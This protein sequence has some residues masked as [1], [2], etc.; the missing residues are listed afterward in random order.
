MRYLINDRENE[1]I[2]RFNAL[3][4]AI[5][6][7]AEAF[8]SPAQTAALRSYDFPGNARQR[9]PAE[10]WQRRLRGMARGE[11]FLI[12]YLI[13]HP[14]AHFAE[15]GCGLGTWCFLA[16]LAGAQDVTG[17]DLNRERL[18]TADQIARNILP[19][20]SSA[21][22]Q[23]LYQSLF[24]AQ[25]QRPVDVFYLK[26]AIHHI[27]PLDQLFE[28]LRKNLS[29]GG[30]V[31]VHDSNAWHPL[32]QWQAWRDR[33]LRK[34]ASMPDPETGERIQYAV[35]DFLSVP[36]LIRQ[37]RRHGFE[38]AHAEAYVG[39]RAR[40]DDRL[41]E[42]ILKPLNQTLPISSLFAMT[43]QIVARAK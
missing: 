26:A 9:L 23:F 20:F 5:T 38:I 29:P 11:Q 32:I 1:I 13:N 4:E 18:E 42:S 37:F 36:G 21:H 12:Q 33:G 27:R 24:R 7:E 17:I 39:L 40:A 6:R 10:A 3:L 28:F 25:F 35:E 2:E 30:V 19:R 22:F 14:G 31:I 41:W 34:L 8:L 43:Y 16:A 15:L